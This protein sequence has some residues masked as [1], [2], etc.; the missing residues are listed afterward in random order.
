ML[1]CVRLA[2]LV[3]HHRDAPGGHGLELLLAVS[4]RREA[5]ARERR[6]LMDEVNV[7]SLRPDSGE[8]RHFQLGIPHPVAVTTLY[9]KADLHGLLRRESCDL[10]PG[11]SLEQAITPDSDSS[12]SEMA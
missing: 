10:G 9:V 12:R 8:L 2:T 11:L 6:P 3:D 1:D 5:L 4:P 7:V